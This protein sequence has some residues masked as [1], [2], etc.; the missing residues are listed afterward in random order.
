[1][2]IIKGWKKYKGEDGWYSKK[3]ILKVI[4][5]K[6]GYYI[7]K[8]QKSPF[9]TWVLRGSQKETKAEVIQFAIKYM[10]THPKG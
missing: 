9:K 1:M 6:K 8:D 4:E 10:K 2:G 5:R 3:S 7:V